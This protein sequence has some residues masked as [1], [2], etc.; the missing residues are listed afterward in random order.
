MKL[1]LLIIIVVMST[2]RCKPKPMFSEE[3]IQKGHFDNYLQQIRE[4]VERVKDSLDFVSKIR[5]LQLE[6]KQATKK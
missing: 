4:D 5:K 1:L 3:E 6:L 2:T